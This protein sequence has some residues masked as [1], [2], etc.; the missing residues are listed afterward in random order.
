MVNYKSKQAGG[1][2]LG[3]ILGLVIGLSI[4][5]VV[6]VMIMKTPIPFIN[7]QARPER[8]E[9][10]GPIAD[11]N[12]PLYGKRD[13]ARNA[14]PETPPAAVA[15]APNPLSSDSRA[16]V[17]ENS[18]L[19]Q[20]KKADPKAEVKPDSGQ[21][22]YYLQAGAFRSQSDAESTRAKLALLGFEARVTEHPSDQGTLYRV[23]MGPFNQIETMNRMRSKLTDNGIDAAVVRTAK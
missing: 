1:T 8:T 18:L 9:A 2:F 3:M 23:R 22:I 11:P 12:Q 14:A 20:P 10:A 19:Q 21:W 15:P 4:A 17:V 6:A 13:A 5:V 16:P 7:K